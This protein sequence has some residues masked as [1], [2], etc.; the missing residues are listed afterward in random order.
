MN[1]DRRRPSTPARQGPRG[2]SPLAGAAALLAALGPLLAAG[3]ARAWDPFWSEDPSVR[4][5]N[6]R[7]LAQAPRDAIEAYRSAPMSQR[8]EVQYDVGLAA[9][10]LAQS[11]TAAAPPPAPPDAS[12]VV[13]PAPP[14]ADAGTTAPPG[15]PD[16]AAGEPPPATPT[17]DLSQCLQGVRPACLRLA[18]SSFARATDSRGDRNLRANAFHSLGNVYLLQAEELKPAEPP[19]LPDLADKECQDVQAALQALEQPLASFDDAISPLDK[20][21]EQFR[22]ALLARPGDDDSAWNLALALRRKRDLEDRRE[23]LRARKAELE[24]LAAEKCKDQ[25]NQDQQNQDQQNQ[26]QQNQ[27]QQNQ[28]QQQQQQQQ[29]QD[30]QNQDRQQQPQ[31][32]EDRQQQQEREQQRQRQENGEEQDIQQQLQNLRDQE[33]LF[34]QM[35]Q[36]EE[37]QQENEA[38]PLQPYRRQAPELDW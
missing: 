24:K 7:F 36:R 32:P 9:V 4:R 14:D 10:A 34:Q 12:P 17:D 18:A 21:I 1:V 38:I 33:E 30:Q 11:A 26:D 6:E 27:D 20:A 28:D 5:G 19:A 35:R 22:S 2:R 23:A 3:T 13:P 25:Q 8:A 29:P 31:Q 15:A 37:A 16:V